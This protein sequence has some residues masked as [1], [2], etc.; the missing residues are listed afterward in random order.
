MTCSEC[1]ILSHCSSGCT[2]TDCGAGSVYCW[3]TELQAP[4]STEQK[5]TSRSSN[6]DRRTARKDNC[7]LCHATKRNRQILPVYSVV[8]RLC[9]VA[10]QEVMSGTI[11]SMP[12][13]PLISVETVSIRWPK[14]G[15]SSSE[16]LRVAK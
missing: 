4:S 9:N 1:D 7:C 8:N 2:A 11:V 15:S 12:S 16:W 3:S 14:T 6:G 13:Q 5:D 10:S